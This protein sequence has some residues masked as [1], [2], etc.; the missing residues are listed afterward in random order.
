MHL[1][2]KADKGWRSGG[3]ETCE[4]G[5]ECIMLSGDGFFEPRVPQP[6]ARTHPQLHHPTSI[7]MGMIAPS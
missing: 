1:V 4:T 3:D 6:P 7:P 5:G 2:V